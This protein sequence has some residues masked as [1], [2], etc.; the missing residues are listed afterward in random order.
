MK[1]LGYENESSRPLE[2]AEEYIGAT[3]K[4]FYLPVEFVFFR[5]R[6]GCPHPGQ[7]MWRASCSGSSREGSLPSP[8]RSAAS[9]CN[10]T[11]A[12]PG[13]RIFAPCAIANSHWSVDNAAASPF[14]HIR[15]AQR[16]R[17]GPIPHRT[18]DRNLAPITHR[19]KLPKTRFFCEIF[20]V[21]CKVRVYKRYCKRIEHN[22]VIHKV[23][24]R[25]EGL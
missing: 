14:I 21:S 25:G 15:M 3:H 19:Y 22:R 5:T 11:G 9:L 18:E 13:Q 16:K 6:S 12:Q 8:Q 2:C 4:M 10:G 23:P 20:F 24:Q 17:G 7:W 1:E